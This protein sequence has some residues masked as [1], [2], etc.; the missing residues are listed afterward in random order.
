MR[1]RITETASFILCIALLVLIP[2]VVAI[3]VAIP[4]AIYH[5]VLHG[6]KAGWVDMIESS[7]FIGY[8]WALLGGTALVWTLATYFLDRKNRRSAPVPQQK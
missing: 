7:R 3:I 4:F 6:W 8:F 5:V 1:Q 2:L